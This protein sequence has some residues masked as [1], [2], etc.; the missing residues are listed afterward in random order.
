MARSVDYDMN[1]EFEL[2]LTDE[3]E[4]SYSRFSVAPAPSGAPYRAV[5]PAGGFRRLPRPARSA[6]VAVAVAVGL[7]GS[8]ALAAAAVTG[9]A[10]PQAWG[11][12]VSDAV[13]T[14]KSE[15]VSGQHGIG[16]CMRAIA[17]QK[18]SQERDQH[19]NGNGSGK[20]HPSP[21]GPPSGVPGGRPNT[22]P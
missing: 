17:H 4:S 3:L 7:I 21:K 2:W 15:L 8:T 19:S 14:C 18:G 6:I 10:N 20:P 16:Q 1:D 13:S 22:T 9:S 11:Q 5:P 12:Y